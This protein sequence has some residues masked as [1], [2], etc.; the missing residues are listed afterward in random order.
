MTRALGL[1]GGIAL[2]FGMVAYRALGEVSFF[3]IANAIVAVATLGLATG[4]L[5]RSFGR[6]QQSSLRTPARRALLGAFAA[7]LGAGTVYWAAERSEVRFDWTFEGS[8]ELAQATRSVLERLPGPLQ[9]TLYYDE[10]D[11]RIRN[12]LLLLEEMARGRP[13]VQVEKRIIDHHPEDE[14]RYGIGSSNSVVLRLGERWRLVPRPS[15]GG[16]FEGLSQL[17]NKP[18][19]TLY[20]SVGAGEGDLERSDDLGFSGL[21][22]ALESEGF[23]ARP[24]PLAVVNRIPQ[25]ASAVVMLAPQR[26]LREPAVRALERYIDRGGRLVAFLEP[27]RG[28]TSGLEELLGRYGL[29]SPDAWVIDPASGPIEGDPAGLNPIVHN[30]A[31]HPVTAGLNSNRMTFFGGARSFALRKAEPEDR[32]R[33][34]LHASGQSWR[35]PAENG[36]RPVAEDLRRPADARRDFHIL[37]ASAEFERGGERE[38]EQRGA[39]ARIL[40]FGDVDLASN[41]YLRALYNLDLVLNGIH[42]VVERDDF[43]TLRPKSGGRQLIQYPVPLQTSLK[44]LYGAGLLVPEVLLIAGGLVWIRQRRG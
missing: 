14:D 10:G 5:I 9:M 12:S 3:V 43:I 7:V 22:S 29:G 19:R 42:W 25:D 16:L 41:R 15:E 26:P 27:A 11:P 24:L 30:Y 17:V 4:L 39:R 33:A 34:V 18:E 13:G 8:F 40:A 44:A 31:D 37:M 2:A 1:V 6:V 28:E 32:V 21:R 20:F 36:V 23:E 38:S 35:L